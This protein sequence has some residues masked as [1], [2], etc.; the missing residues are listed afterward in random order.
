VITF[1]VWK[2]ASP[3]YR[4]IFTHKHVN[5]FKAM[6]DRHYAEPHRLICITDNTDGVECETFPLWK[7][8]AG[9]RNPSGAML[10]S[11]YR[12]LKLFIAATD[13]I[14][15]AKG[16]RVVSMDLDVVLVGDLKPLFERDDEFVG[17]RGVGS[18]R[19]VVYNGSLFM[20]KAGCMRWLWD[21]FDPEKSPQQTREARYFGSDQAWLSL[22]LNGTA[23][24]WDIADGVYS[25]SRDLRQRPLPDN[26]R[27]VSFNGKHKPWDARSQAETPWIRKHWRA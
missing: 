18:F 13:D 3:E 25:Y 26:A 11:C 1:V 4:T 16:E 27:I 24:G 5:T 14:G 6:L 7:D 9:L 12:R 20:F 15:I 17:W 10:P 21:E 22:K 19:P 2:W 23:P 8:C